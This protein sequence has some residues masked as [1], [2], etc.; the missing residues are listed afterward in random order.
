VGTQS[1]KRD[2]S[3]DSV[4]YVPNRRD[5]TVPVY[6]CPGVPPALNRLAETP[7]TREETVGRILRTRRNSGAQQV[8][9]RHVCVHGVNDGLAGA[10]VCAAADCI[11]VEERA[12]RTG[13]GGHGA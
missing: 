4:P 6:I 10:Q 3:R 7:H 2:M 5:G 8:A 11:S 1:I 9:F 13:G 12:F